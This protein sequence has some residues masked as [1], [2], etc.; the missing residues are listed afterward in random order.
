MQNLADLVKSQNAFE[1]DSDLDEDEFQKEMRKMER[2]NSDI[3]TSL[4][5]FEQQDNWFWIEH[6]TK[7]S[8]NAG[9]EVVEKQEQ[10]Q[11][12]YQEILIFIKMIDSFEDE[13]SRDNQM[14]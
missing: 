1:S 10:T 3:R 5:E 13:T 14:L 6:F 8:N 11:L 12:T 2:A 7:V 4:L 9:S